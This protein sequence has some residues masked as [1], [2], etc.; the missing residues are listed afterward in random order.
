MGLIHVVEDAR[1]ALPEAHVADIESRIPWKGHE[2]EAWLALRDVL[3]VEQ[4]VRGMCEKGCKAYD[5]TPM[6][7]PNLPDIEETRR[8]FSA[9]DTA[10]L[11]RY[12]GFHRWS[13]IPKLHAAKSLSDLVPED[14]AELRNRRGLRLKIREIAT[15]VEEL[16]Y[17]TL[18]MSAGHCR[19]CEPPTCNASECRQPNVTMPAVEGMGVHVFKTMEKL[20][21]EMHYL[22]PDYE[23]FSFYNA[24]LINS[25]ARKK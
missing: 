12:N 14:R 11:V 8:I 17:D 25:Q 16:G 22:P 1:T 9:Y 23:G 7:P 3:V 18:P 4:W 6:C 5:T 13:D 20:G 24:I 2:A 19:L 15:A 21:H 10:L